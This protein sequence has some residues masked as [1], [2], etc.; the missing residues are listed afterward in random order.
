MSCDLF[1]INIFYKCVI[2][3]RAP[4]IVH[5][6][7]SSAHRAAYRCGSAAGNDNGLIRA[8]QMK[9]G[10]S[11]MPERRC[12]VSAGVNTAPHGSA[13][14]CDHGQVNVSL[15]IQRFLRRLD[16]RFGAR[17]QLGVYIND[18]AAPCAVNQ[19]G[20]NAGY[21]KRDEK[22]HGIAQNFQ[23]RVFKV[24]YPVAEKKQQRADGGNKDDKHR[25]SFQYAAS[26]V[27]LQI[28]RQLL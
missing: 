20:G 4:D 17:G 3:P 10:V 19:L 5:V 2:A 11:D 7:A 6:T 12:V 15:R 25:K 16:R 13:V 27:F 24:E 9:H 26:Y 18:F 28:L 21:P 1:G 23:P 14:R 8:V 22:R